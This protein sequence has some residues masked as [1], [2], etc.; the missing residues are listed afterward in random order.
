[1]IRNR[2]SRLLGSAQLL[3]LRREMAQLHGECD[4]LRDEV[5]YLK[6]SLEIPGTLYDEFRD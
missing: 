4:A 5:D 2:I 6:S 1:M 3:D